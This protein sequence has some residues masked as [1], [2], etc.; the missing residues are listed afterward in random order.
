VSEI[1]QSG[2]KP[3]IVL[4]ITIVLLLLLAM[5][6]ALGYKKFMQIQTMMAQGSIA[7]PP[8]SV[9]VAEAK[10]ADWN[11]RIKAIG[12]LIAYQGVE[13]SSEVAGIVTSINFVSGQE[14]ETGKLLVELDSQSELATLA[15]AKAQ[16]ESD[17]SQYQRWIKL[18]DQEFVTKNALDTQLALV[19]IAKSR[20]GIAEAALA[21]KSVAAPFSGKLG[22]RQ[23]DLGEYVAPGTSIVTLQSIDQLLL[24]FTLPESNFKDLAVGLSVTFKVRSYPGRTFTGTV[25]AWN[26]LL[27]ENTRN[28]AIRAEVDNTERQLAPGMFAEIEVESR[29]TLSVLTVPET[30]IFYNIYGEAVYVLEKPE[31][32]DA[33]S[34]P[35]DPNPEYILAARQVQVAYRVG[36]VAGVSEGLKAGD[37]VV[38][39]GQLKLFPS[40]KVAI[41]DDVAEYQATKSTGQ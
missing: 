15:S 26:P 34:D 6:G 21:K 11:K 35:A 31:A 22:I 13:I 38:T 3:R 12:T 1:D 28:V 30:S 17:N 14:V 7:P 23:I 39:A 4:R 36:G 40:L 41:V 27:D 19:D 24:D 29:Q 5:T 18:K 9:T 32:S 33:D 37:Q 20:I 8:I 16:Y 10:A 25:T 2:N